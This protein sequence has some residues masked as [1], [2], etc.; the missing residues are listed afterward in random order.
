MEVAGVVTHRQRPGTAKGVIFHQPRGR[1]RSLE[2]DLLP[3]PVAASPA[4]GPH[5]VGA[6]GARHPRAPPR[7][8]EPRRPPSGTAAGGGGSPL[9]GLPLAPTS[10]D[11][12]SPVPG[13]PSRQQSALRGPTPPARSTAAP[14]APGG[15]V[16]RRG[17]RTAGRGG[18]TTPPPRR[19][20]A[21]SWPPGVA[22]SPPVGRG[23][24]RRSATTR[25][26]SASASEIG[27][28]GIM[29]PSV[30]TNPTFD[31]APGRRRRPDRSRCRPPWWPRR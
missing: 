16:R 28:V 19:S 13:S 20:R 21:G 3:R 22:G 30:P 4:G 31:T 23:P 29:L 11:P 10:P 18:T 5:V 14:P 7:G 15:C 27:A 24:R 8:R 17:R 12:G 6:A 25:S 9:Q 26:A 1:D 2:R